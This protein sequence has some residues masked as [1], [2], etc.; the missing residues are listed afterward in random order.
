MYAIRMGS[1]LDV[2][3]LQKSK[4]LNR[5]WLFLLELGKNANFKQTCCAAI[6]EVLLKRR[7][8]PHTHT[9]THVA[10]SLIHQIMKLF[11]DFW[12]YLYKS[13][14]AQSDRE[15][16]RESCITFQTTIIFIIIRVK[17]ILNYIGRMFDTKN[18][19]LSRAIIKQ[20][21]RVAMRP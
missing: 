11:F 2:M 17:N 9:H 1:S 4:A 13:I 18:S 14:W 16:E 15:R 3:C 20:S 12:I 6:S 19:P 8:E 10:F 5:K 7:P 21:E